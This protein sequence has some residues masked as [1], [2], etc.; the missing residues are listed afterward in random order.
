MQYRPNFI[1][2]F[3]YQRPIERNLIILITSE[4]NSFYDRGVTLQILMEKVL[5]IFQ[6]YR[7]DY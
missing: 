4:T 2:I 6:V 7:L 3:A 5:K 1:F